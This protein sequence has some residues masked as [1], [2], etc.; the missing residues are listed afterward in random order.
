MPLTSPIGSMASDSHNRPTDRPTIDPMALM[1]GRTRL[2]HPPTKGVFVTRHSGASLRAKTGIGKRLGNTDDMKVK[3][4]V[5]LVSRFCPAA[6]VVDHSSASASLRTRKAGQTLIA[7]WAT[8]TAD[9]VTVSP[10][11][12]VGMCMWSCCPTHSLV[13]KICMFTTRDQKQLSQ[14][15]PS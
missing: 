13:M 7:L 8:R 15:C 14:I 1:V 9:R 12:C 5:R 11:N 10:L 6:T 4:H 3:L 2:L